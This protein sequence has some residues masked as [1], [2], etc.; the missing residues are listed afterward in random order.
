[1]YCGFVSEK[2]FLLLEQAL[3]VHCFADCRKSKDQVA[4]PL[5]WPFSFVWYTRSSGNLQKTKD[6]LINLCGKSILSISEM[7]IFFSKTEEIVNFLA[8]AYR[9]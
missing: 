3:F 7:G 9:K 4:V 5:T 6:G 1:V 2:P 8:E